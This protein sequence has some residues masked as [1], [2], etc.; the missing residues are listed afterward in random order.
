MQR[1]IGKSCHLK[2]KPEQKIVQS[3]L[4]LARKKRATRSRM[5]LLFAYDLLPRAIRCGRREGGEGACVTLGLSLHVLSLI[6]FSLITCLCL[7]GASVTFVCVCVCVVWMCVRV[8]GGQQQS[9]D[10]VSASRLPGN[11]FRPLSWEVSQT[12][13]GRRR[14]RRR[15]RRFSRT[16]CDKNGQPATAEMNAWKR[17]SVKMKV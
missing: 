14:R 9:F 4:A 16:G 11:H 6:F 17:R 3:A 13:V 10:R 15:R 2:K 5:A 12:W 1:S 8:Q 7:D